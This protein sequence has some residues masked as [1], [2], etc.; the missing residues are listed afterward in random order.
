MI[1]LEKFG[2]LGGGEALGG[3]VLVAPTSIA[4]T[5]TSASIG[6]NGTVTFSAITSLSLNG[7]FT[8]SYSNY[9][10][11][12]GDSYTLDGQDVDFRLRA[13]GTNATGANYS[14]QKLS[15][16][17]STISGF[18]YT[19]DTIWANAFSGTQRNGS[20]THLYGPFLSQ[21]TAYRNITVGQYT[22]AEAVIQDWVGTHS[23]SSSYDGFSLITTSTYTLTGTLSV[24]GLVGA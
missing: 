21:P 24:Y 17:N 13:S 5:G 10:I 11:V 8:A 1:L 22:G 18:R 4:Y 7:V 2:A 3:M 20:T 14:R 6:A 15:A 12:I 19:N 16:D 9:V 23:L